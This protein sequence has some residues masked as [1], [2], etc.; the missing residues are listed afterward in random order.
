[1]NSYLVDQQSWPYIIQLLYIMEN[2]DK[3]I[4]IAGIYF[5]LSK[6]FDSINHALLIEKLANYGIRGMCSNLLESYLQNRRQAVCVTQN[7]E[8]YIS[9]PRDISQGIPQ[10]SILGPLLFSLCQR[11]GGAVECGNGLPIYVRWQISLRMLCQRL[12]RWP[13]EIWRN[14]VRTIA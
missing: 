3:N 13:S 12:V 8:S 6:A 14:G 7:S 2:L 1:M 5:D 11:A 9:R 4:K 10:G